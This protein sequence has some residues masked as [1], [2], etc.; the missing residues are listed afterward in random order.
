MIWEMNM[1]VHRLLIP[2]GWK[3]LVPKFFYI[4]LTFGWTI[5]KPDQCFLAAPQQAP[6][7]TSLQ[8]PVRNMT[9]ETRNGRLPPLSLTNKGDWIA[10]IQSWFF[11]SCNSC[12]MLSKHRN[13]CNQRPHLQHFHTN[14]VHTK[15][16]E[17]LIRLFYSLLVHTFV[18][19]LGVVERHVKNA[20]R[21]SWKFFKGN[22]CALK[23]AYP[24]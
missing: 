19:S 6:R 13:Y 22:N 15:C 21:L 5:S 9:Q 24:C 2:Q 1:H 11:K 7:G 4:Y 23:K 8:L 10:P 12:M 14:W 18:W 16:N 20:D 3:P 17:K